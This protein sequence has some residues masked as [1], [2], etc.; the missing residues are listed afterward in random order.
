MQKMIEIKCDKE[1][2]QKICTGNF[3]TWTT[4][5]GQADPETGAE[6]LEAYHLC[7]KCDTLERKSMTRLEGEKPEQTKK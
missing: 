5:S 1:K 6:I 7:N 3:S 2:C 4:G